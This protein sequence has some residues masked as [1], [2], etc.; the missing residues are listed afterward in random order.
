M[1]TRQELSANPRAWRVAW[2]AAAMVVCPSASWAQT[3]LNN[4]VVQYHDVASPAQKSY[5]FEF[6]AP[7]WVFLR[8][9]DGQP[10]AQLSLDRPDNV[11]IEYGHQASGTR[12]TMRF[13]PAGPHAVTLHGGDVGRLQVRRVPEIRFCKYQ[14]D[15]WVTEEGPYDWAFLERYL[16]P[17][18]NTIVGKSHQDQSDRAIPWRAHGGRWI[19]ET[20]APG[21]DR[22][23]LPPE[24]RTLS[25]E[26]AFTG[27]TSAVKFDQPWID[28]QVVDEY[29]QTLEYMFKPTTQA[30]ARIHA[31]TR[32]AGKRIDLYIAGK[33]KKFPQLLINTVQAGAKIT[34]E[35]YHAEQPTEAEARAYLQEEFVDRMAGYRRVVPDAP[36]Q[37]VVALGI[38]SAPPESLDVRPTANYHVFQD[39]EFQLL[40][41][42]PAFDGLFG[43]MTYTSGYA[44]AETLRWVGRLYR[45]YCI[46]GRTTRL[47][48]DPYRLTHLK[49]PDFAEGTRGWEIQPAA[50][51]SIETRQISGLGYRQG[52]Y[53]RRTQ[54][55]D[56]CLVMTRS[57]AG[58]N[59]IRQPIKNLT[60]GRVY[61]LRMFSTRL[62]QPAATPQT[63]SGLN[64]VVDKVALLPEK[65]YDHRYR[66]IHATEPEYFTYHVRRFRAT[67]TTAM[68]TIS[69]GAVDGNCPH[70][71]PCETAVNFIEL[72]PYE[73][74]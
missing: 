1:S 32:F 55:G 26:E 58:P 65:C 23:D 72:L 74:P 71:R 10:G 24:K 60:P 56:S 18:V 42:D 43:V 35:A 69:D 38:F 5:R 17:H 70:D 45:H 52:R 51:G 19:I 46:E 33:A 7:S 68:L 16:L 31:D 2:L 28:G 54:I 62:D 29:Y 36:R 67:Q 63:A 12:E 47:S 73:M 21:L 53:V 25:A 41:N 66:S 34:F 49:N 3:R 50:A 14:Y 22:K 15:P 6:S 11:V 61:A 13:L 40:A 39:L 48:R 4:L 44:E 59:V 64:I 27:L 57:A 37:M 30:V 20:Y 9:F 8:T